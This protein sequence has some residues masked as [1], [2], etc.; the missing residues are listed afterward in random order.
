MDV[1]PD[2]DLLMERYSKLLGV[3]PARPSLDYLTNLT[4][5]QLQRV[6]FENVSKLYYRKRYRLE[7]LPDL[8]RHLDGIEHYRFGGT[9]YAN[10]T[11]FYR[12]LRHVGFGARLCGADMETADAHFVIGVAVEGREFLVDAGYAAPLLAPLPRDLDTDYVIALGRDRYVLEPQ[13]AHGRSRLVLYRDGQRTHGYLAKPASRRI[14]EF[15]DVIAAS[16]RPEAVFM[17]ALLLVRFFPGRSITIHNLK[18]IV[19]EGPHWTERTL[20]GVDE[21]AVVVQENFGIPH[22]V[23]DEVVADLD[24]SGDPWG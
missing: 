17:N 5:A 11:Y 7:G 14:E 24:L 13:D 9:C 21:L 6:P 10:N 15:A 1:S 23:V 12:F 16:F 19:A 3:P 18:L 20:S 2:S 4:A 22:E 8:A